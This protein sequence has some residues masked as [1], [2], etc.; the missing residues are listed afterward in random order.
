MPSPEHNPKKGIGH[1]SRK[2]NKIHRGSNRVRCNYCGNDSQIV[3]VHGHGQC[4]MCGTNIDECC[5]GEQV[6]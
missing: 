4:R 5:R 1:Y 3:W 6:N 2:L